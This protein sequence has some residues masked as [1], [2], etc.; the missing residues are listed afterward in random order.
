MTGIVKQ[1]AA[2][3]DAGTA[4]ERHSDIARGIMAGVA[5]GLASWS[6]MVMTI[7]WVF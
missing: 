5:L 3:W 4:P 2:D 7:R 1:P 6:L